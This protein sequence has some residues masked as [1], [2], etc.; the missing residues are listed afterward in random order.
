LRLSLRRI[1]IPVIRRIGRI[2]QVNRPGYNIKKNS[3]H[4]KL[5]LPYINSFTAIYKNLDKLLNKFFSKYKENSYKRKLRSFSQ[6]NLIIS[7]I[8]HRKIRGIRV[9]A[10]GRL[11]RRRTAARP[12]FKM[13]HIGGL[14]NV[15]SRIKGWSAIM[16]RGDQ[17]S[18]VQYSIVNTNGRNGA[19]GLKGWVSSR[20]ITN[21]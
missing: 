15:I 4:N 8:K 17:K 16:L 11:T 1:T 18:N 21:N 14:N 10:K 20:S 2:N 12:L 7:N 3:L 9:E 19:F 5:I 13:R 6:K